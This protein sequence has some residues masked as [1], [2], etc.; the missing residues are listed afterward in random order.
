MPIKSMSKIFVER[1]YITRDPVGMA[2]DSIR[3]TFVEIPRKRIWLNV[4]LC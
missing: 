2:R 1:K 3:E 4:R